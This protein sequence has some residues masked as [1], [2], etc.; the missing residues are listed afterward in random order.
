M[1]TFIAGL[2]DLLSHPLTRGADLDDPRTTD[3]RLQVV[4]GKPFLRRIYD[5]W[6]GLIGSRVPAGSGAILELGSGAGYFKEV[7]PS[8]IR[9]EIFHCSNVD[10]VADARRLPARSGSLKAIVMTDVF[11]HIPQPEAFLDEAVRCLRPGGRIVMIEPWVCGWSTFVYR[12][13]HHEPFEPGAEQWEIPDSGPLSSA[14]GA[15]PWIVTVRDRERLRR[16]FPELEVEEVLPMMPV[17]YLVSGGISMRN[18]VP[19]A[20]HGAWKALEDVALRWN[21]NFGMFALFSL[22]RG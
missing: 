22:K 21:R 6:Y 18:L 14:N 9:S 10:V 20:T 11:H 19:S 12:H 15:L 13:F 1:A 2:R 3:L 16:R 8:T 17:R 7:L 4:R 5:E